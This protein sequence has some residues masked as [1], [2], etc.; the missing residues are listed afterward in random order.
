[1]GS[2]AR[3]RS[4]RRWHFYFNPRSR[5]G[6]DGYFLPAAISPLY[7]NP[8][9]RVG[10]DLPGVPQSRL[11]NISIHAPAWGATRIRGENPA[12]P[13]DFNPRSR[14]G[15]DHAFAIKALSETDFNPRSRVGS[16]DTS[17]LEAGLKRTF[18]STLP[19]G[20]RRRIPLSHTQ[21]IYFNPRSRVG[22]DDGGV[23]VC[24]PGR[25]F[26]P[27]S[28]V[29]SDDGLC[30][31]RP[32]PLP[33][34]IHAPA[35]GATNAWADGPA[36]AGISIH[37]PAWGATRDRAGGRVCRTISIHAPAWGATCQ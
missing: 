19:R 3:C 9:S 14:V 6:S 34:S 23:P 4:S 8:R 26:N 5:V 18:Q 2:D 13:F 22:S 12:L 25:N 27:R 16:D 33:I 21:P 36:P 1:M 7:F 11:Y 29:G 32:A 15:S 28:R 24:E 35:W 20:E 30:T 31:Q 17:K 10:S 37:A